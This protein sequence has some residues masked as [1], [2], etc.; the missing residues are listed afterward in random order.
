MSGP[1]SDQRGH[2]PKYLGAQ[3]K[4][5]VRASECAV[6]RERRGV[7]FADDPTKRE[8]IGAAC[9][10]QSATGILLDQQDTRGTLPGDAGENC[11]KFGREDGRQAE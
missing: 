11:E 1:Q 7:S 5:K 4:P 3:S 8:Q 10:R 6:M 2:D 9:Q